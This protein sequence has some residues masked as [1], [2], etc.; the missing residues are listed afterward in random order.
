MEN[1]VTDIERHR[2]MMPYAK[3]HE[4]ALWNK[5]MANWNKYDWQEF[6]SVKNGNKP[7]LLDPKTNYRDI[8]CHSDSQRFKLTSIRT[9]VVHIGTASQLRHTIGV[10]RARVYE[11]NVK[12]Y[13][14]ERI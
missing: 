10:V 1:R 6:E 13:L 14:T 7:A 3:L 2:V 9:G 12:G 4:W 5:T 11:L 8:V